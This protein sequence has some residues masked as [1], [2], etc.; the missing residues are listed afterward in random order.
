MAGS[1]DVPKQALSRCPSCLHNFFNIYCYFTCAP[2]HN[3]FVYP[4]KTTP[5]VDP[6]TNKTGLQ[7]NMVRH[8]LPILYA[9]V[10]VGRFYSAILRSRADSLR[11]LVILHE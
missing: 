5:Y 6:K 3:Q 7:V 9:V 1:M 11:L 8:I 4:S 10:V 2:N